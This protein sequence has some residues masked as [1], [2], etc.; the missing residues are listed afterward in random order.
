MNPNCEKIRLSNGLVALVD[1]DDFKQISKHNWFPRK[2]GIWRIR[3]SK[4]TETTLVK[5]IRDWLV[6][7]GCLPLKYHGSVYG[8]SGH[9][10]IYGVLPDGKAF[11]LEVKLPGKK[12]EPKQ[13]AFLKL[14]DSYG[15]V[16]GWCDSLEGAK[17]IMR[18]HLVGGKR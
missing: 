13:V 6:Q 7:E 2:E 9:S 15:A 3:Q 10:D 5:K 11:F 18:P 17:R 8:Y 1:E 4:M 12:P 14:V 16:T